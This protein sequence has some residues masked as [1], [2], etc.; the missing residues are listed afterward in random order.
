MDRIKVL[1]VDDHRVVRDGL[2]KILESCND[3]H[4]I[5]EAANGLEAIRKYSE[6]KPD[7][8]LLDISMPKLGGLEVSRRIKKENPSAK[9]VIL[10]MHEEEEYSMKLVRLGVSGYLLKDSA[11]QEVIEAVRTAFAGRAYFSPQ[12]SK[13][14]AESYRE[15]A[16]I[17][18]D[19]YERLNDR[20]REVLQLIAE[21]HTNKAIADILFI[22]PKTVDNHRTNLMRKLNIHSAADLVRWATKRGLVG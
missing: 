10:S 2:S 14:L 9:I 5:G 1:I 16:P 3:I 11:A 18:D 12:I 13:T 8:I 4:V 15:V 6:L 22:S 21:G 20:E 17:E 19:P 7:V